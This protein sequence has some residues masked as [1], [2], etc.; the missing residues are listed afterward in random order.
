MIYTEYM[1]TLP[2]CNLSPSFSTSGRTAHLLYRI[3]GSRDRGTCL[4]RAAAQVLRNHATREIHRETL[5][6]HGM[7]R[8]LKERDESNAKMMERY[9]KMMEIEKGLQQNEGE[10]KYIMVMS[11]CE[12]GRLSF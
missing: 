3:S 8:T 7:K 9:G 4:G 5:G 2:E 10:G 12:K 1:R 11:K 6:I